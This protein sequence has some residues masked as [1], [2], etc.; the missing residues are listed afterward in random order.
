MATFDVSQACNLR[1][2]NK[3]T[4]A[5]IGKQFGVSKQAIHRLIKP[6][7]PTEAT[8]TFKEQRADILA[9]LQLNLLS[10]VDS[11]R[12][13]K[14]G[15]R[16]LVVSAGILYDKERLERGQSTQNVAYNVITERL[17]KIKEEQESIDKQLAE[18]GYVEPGNTETQN[19]DTV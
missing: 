8:K 9:N 12:L 19:S 14:T 5:Q 1:I 15:V 7:L 11:V 2:N 16:D 17:A 10:N 4:Y 3:L 18:L 6:L 13:K